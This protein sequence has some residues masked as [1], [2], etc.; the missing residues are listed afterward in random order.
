MKFFSDPNPDN[1]ED[2]RSSS[3]RSFLKEQERNLKHAIGHGP[4]S[5]S[6]RDGSR[7]VPSSDN[8]TRRPLYIPSPGS[9]F[10][11]QSSETSLDRKLERYAERRSQ[12]KSLRAETELKKRQ[13]ELMQRQ[14]A[15]SEAKLDR[16]NKMVSQKMKSNALKNIK[17]ASSRRATRAA[18]KEGAKIA[19]YLN[20][21]K[22]RSESRRALR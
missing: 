18:A 2:R 3:R 8:A 7:R 13:I 9:K 12:M 20:S 17:R 19:E 15:S 11:T 1:K 22:L 16:F 14:V 21:S 6:R 10:S 4:R 5:S